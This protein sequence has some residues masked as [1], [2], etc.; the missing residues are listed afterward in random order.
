MKLLYPVDYWQITD[1]A[2]QKV[3]ETFVTRME[4]FVGIKRTN[5][6]LAEIWEK[7]RPDYVNVSLAEYMHSAFAWSANRDQWLHLLKPFIEE[8]TEK[9]GKPPVL[10]PQVRFK[11]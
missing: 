8:Y 5:I 2:S 11:V 6:H 3:F 10:N 1:E 9:F 4:N 7:Q